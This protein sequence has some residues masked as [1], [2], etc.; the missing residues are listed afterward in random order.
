MS[1]SPEPAVSTQ[2]EGTWPPEYYSDL[3]P[4]V[5]G[6]KPYPPPRL[7]FSEAE[8]RA[9]ALWSSAPGVKCQLEERRLPEDDG[10]ETLALIHE[11]LAKEELERRAAHDAPSNKYNLRSRTKIQKYSSSLA[12]P[13]RARVDKPSRKQ[14]QR[15]QKQEASR[16][17]SANAKN[18]TSNANVAE[19]T[20]P[21]ESTT[22]QDT[23]KVAK[24]PK[25]T[26]TLTT[27]KKAGA[28][29]AAK[30]A[31]ATADI[32]KTAAKPPA[33]RTAKTAR[34]TSAVKD[35]RVV[36]SQPSARR[37]TLRKQGS[38]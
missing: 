33:R 19:T 20:E 7:P 34:K 2:S 32:S 37:T 14:S 16:K 21:S 15:G 12:E 13:T 1:P 9:K 23:P 35:A 36:K 28:A 25:I 17:V 22:A 38:K 24:L 29:K 3:A 11:I 31:S 18:T 26:R 8:I 30:F 6:V 10:G 5:Y 27:A 4:Y